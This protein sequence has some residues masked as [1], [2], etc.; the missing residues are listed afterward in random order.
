MDWRTGEDNCGTGD[1]DEPEKKPGGNDCTAAKRRGVTLDGQ[2]P[3]CEE[4]NK[5]K[6][7]CKNGTTKK[8]QNGSSS[9]EAK[10][11]HSKKPAKTSGSSSKNEDCPAGCPT[12]F[13]PC[14]MK[15]TPPPFCHPLGVWMAQIQPCPPKSGKSKE[16]KPS[17]PK[18]PK[19]ASSGK[20]TKKAS[21]SKSSNVKEEPC[22][23]DK[24]CK[25]HC[26]NHPPGI[27]PSNPY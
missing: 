2:N 14:E 11:T 24:P 13:K 12:G 23:Y 6:E 15:L 4:N 22:L 3:C 19:A 10:H 20:A 1:C 25:A 27:K 21:A 5:K 8:E 9:G 16:D 26:F 7:K 17:K 18:K